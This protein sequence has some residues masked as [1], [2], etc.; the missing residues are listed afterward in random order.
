MRPGIHAAY[1]DSN[2]KLIVETTFGREN[3]VVAL[4]SDKKWCNCP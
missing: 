4:K 2:L 3:P 1:R